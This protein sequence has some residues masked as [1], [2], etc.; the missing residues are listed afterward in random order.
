MEE[1]DNQPL[2]VVL[3]TPEQRVHNIVSVHMYVLTF[4]SL[5]NLEKVAFISSR[6]LC[7]ALSNEDI[8]LSLLPARDNESFSVSA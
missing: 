6:N 8:S 1:D 3:P 2:G 5:S 7:D 4:A